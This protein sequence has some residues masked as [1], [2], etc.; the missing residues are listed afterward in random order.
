[1]QLPPT[2]LKFIW[3]SEGWLHD[4]RQPDVPHAYPFGHEPPAPALHVPTPSHVP[5][6]EAPQMVLVDG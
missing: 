6:Q 2:Q 1:L 4:V 5:L 3:Q